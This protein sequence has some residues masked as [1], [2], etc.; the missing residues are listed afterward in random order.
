MELNLMRPL[1]TP[2]QSREIDNLLIRQL[3]IESYQLMQRAGRACFSELIKR[4]PNISKIAI[5]AG[6]GNN[7][8]DGYVLACLLHQAHREV[9]VFQVGAV[10]SIRRDALKAYQDY[11]AQ[12]GQ[13][14]TLDEFLIQKDTAKPADFQHY[15]LIVDAI[16]GSGLNRDLPEE[17]QAMIETI[18]HHPAPVLAVDIPSGLNA[19]NGCAQPL[20]VEA[21]ITV[22][23]ITRKR[24]LYTAAGRDYCGEIIFDD[25][26]APKQIVKQLV[27]DAWLATYREVRTLLVPRRN[28][29]HKKQFGYLLVV[30]GNSGMVGAVRLTAESALRAGAGL[31]SVGTRPHHA[32]A[33]AAACPV[34]M[35]HD[36]ADVE[37]LQKLLHQADVIVIGPGLGL[38]RWAMAMLD[39]VLNSRRPLVIDADALNLLAK[40]KQTSEHW[41]LTPHPG[42]A[43]RLLGISTAEVQADR[44][45]AAQ[46]IQLHYG[47]IC[48]LKG[49]GTIVR[50]ATRTVVCEGGNAAMSSAGMG[51]VLCG[52]VAALLGQGLSNEDAAVLGVCL[53]AQAGDIA[54]VNRPH[55][56]IATDLMDYLSG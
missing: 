6:V 9:C 3:P 38:D 56:L 53:H 1:Y 33:L 32:V 12:G 8:G 43:A 48:I 24:G 7:G 11:L 5:F 36:V 27:P 20:A 39:T 16:F 15:E 10:N 37:A 4:W 2:K 54:T 21:T 55:G 19:N 29:T 26:Q 45:D 14:A 34:L 31:V 44:F 13:V 35:A 22:S 49:A 41:I 30:G 40:D 17:V 51:D 47:G 52:V 28:N 25:L 23:F 42:E 18:N 50:T 46:Q